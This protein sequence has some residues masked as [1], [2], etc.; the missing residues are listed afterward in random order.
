MKKRDLFGK[1]RRNIIF[2]C[3]GI[4]VVTLITFAIITEQVYKVNLF[5]TVDDQLKT[6]RNMI[7][8]ELHLKKNSEGEV[9]EAILP[10]PL[11][12]ELI[13]FVWW[14]GKLV[15]ESPHPYKGEDSYPTFSNYSWGDFVTVRDGDFVY[16][17]VQFEKDGA[18]IQL[19]INVNDELVYVQD[20]EKALSSAFLILILVALGLATY[21]AAV[22]L[23]PLRSSYNKQVA[24]VQ[25]ASHE[26]RTPLA[27]IK[28]RLEL[29]AKNS[30]DQIEDHFEELSTMMEEIRG[31]EKLNS[32][33]LLMSKEDI[34]GKLELTSFS[35]NAFIQEIY[36]FYF[37]LAEVQD[38][39]F[40]LKNIEEEIEVEWDQVK[41]KRC[42]SILLENAL[43]YTTSGD[44]ICLEARR[45]EGSIQLC[46]LDTGI[47]IKKEEQDRI[48][49]RFFRGQ[50][51]RASGI[52]GS[53][54][55]LSLLKSLCYNLNIKIQLQSKYGE[56]TCFTLI[57]P[58]KM[59]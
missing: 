27:I 58:I 33:L 52:E 38:K 10:A 31:L 15:S 36:S 53:G 35:L 48:F 30:S 8:T 14:D 23:K 1:T 29:L 32:D 49:D 7:L 54:I 16:R 50:E 42:M 43:K 34:G 39:S 37:D 57:L 4:V 56:G 51:V 19:L 18:I 20:L 28:G 5:K 9:E 40:I 11:I 6:H 47:G 3:L 26:M 41:I 59:D 2:L 17:G 22:V 25:D 21:L 13:R 45:K 46:I 12:K 55:G 44:Q 24:F